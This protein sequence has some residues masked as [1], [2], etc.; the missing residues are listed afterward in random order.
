VIEFMAESGGNVL[1]VRATGKLSRAD[2]RDSLMP[3]TQSL[4]DRFPRLR[5][6]FLMDEAF[7]GWSLG[8]AWTNT[9]FDVKH[10]RDFEKVAMVGA[11]KWE[12]RCV[13]TAAT[14]LMNGE[15]RTFRHDQL[16]EA[17]QWLRA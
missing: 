15:L 10:R 6:L 11:P 17:W 1:G 13:R 12:E 7:Q 8:A 3:R 4:L 14:F 2:Y 5:V 16:A 9:T